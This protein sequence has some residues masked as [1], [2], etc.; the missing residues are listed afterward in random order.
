MNS[1]ESDAADCVENGKLCS[2]INSCLQIPAI[3]QLGM[4]F[5]HRVVKYIKFLFMVLKSFPVAKFW[6]RFP[7]RRQEV[8]TSYCFGSLRYV[9]KLIWIWHQVNKL[10][11]EYMR[12]KK[13][14]VLRIQ[15]CIFWELFGNNTYVF[16][17]VL[18][19]FHFMP[20]LSHILFFQDGLNGNTNLIIN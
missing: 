19:I 20:V 11:N 5:I 6:R 9:T 4:V 15:L 7:L 13:N 16:Y 1:F 3:L 12:R 17:K 14:N 2:F 10:Y 8:A 18:D